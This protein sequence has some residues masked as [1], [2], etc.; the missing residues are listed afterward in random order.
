MELTCS[1]DTSDFD[2][3]FSCSSTSSDR[4]YLEPGNVFNYLPT[5]LILY[6]FEFLTPDSVVDV[7]LTCQFFNLVSESTWKSLCYKR[8]RYKKVDFNEMNQLYREQERKIS[9]RLRKSKSFTNTLKKKLSKKRHII[10]SQFPCGDNITDI[11]WKFLYYNKT[12]L[13]NCGWL[14]EAKPKMQFPFIMRGDPIP[15]AYSYHLFPTVVAFQD[16][17][18]IAGSGAYELSGDPTTLLIERRAI[19]AWS[20]KT[21]KY[22]YS[23]EGHQ[24]AVTEIQFDKNQ[25]ITSSRDTS[26]KLWNVD[27]GELLR[28]YYGH[29]RCVNSVHM[30]GNRIYSCSRDHTIKIWNRGDTEIL[31]NIEFERDIRC[32]AFDDSN[33]M[34]TSSNGK[35]GFYDIE[36]LQAVAELEPTENSIQCM[37]TYKNDLIF[38]SNKNMFHL[39]LRSREIVR[40]FSRGHKK[41]GFSANFR[42]V[43]FDDNK[44]VSVDFKGNLFSVDWN[45]GTVLSTLRM[46]R[47]TCFD[48]KENENFLV[49]GTSD[50][51]IRFWDFS[52]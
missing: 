12:K 23:S 28:T 16:D 41:K 32:F 3:T 4:L 18:L 2:R 46:K 47:R 27:D 44:L 17:I 24:G 1:S 52:S 35:L 51:L 5:E 13:K 43:K 30:E 8:Y 15:G 38:G 33:N 14:T 45:T 40:K 21:G 6:V 22:I 10:S 50:K 42:Q 26:M 48:F 7:S 29:T 34:M 39:D 20:I 49:T 25:Y 37:Y 9:P 36:T 19:K 31:G 11:S